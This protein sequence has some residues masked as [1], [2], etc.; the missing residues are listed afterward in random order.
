MR[1][2][3]GSRRYMLRSCAHRSRSKTTRQT[4][5]A[6]ALAMPITVLTLIALLGSTCSAGLASSGDL[7]RSGTGVNDRAE[8][9]DQ[10]HGHVSSYSVNKP[11]SPLFRVRGSP[12]AHTL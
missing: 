1:M 2:V 7:R 11:M 5:A 4:L 8:K 6:A 9:T 3:P 12:L 10:G